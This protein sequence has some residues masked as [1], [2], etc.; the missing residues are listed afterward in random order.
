MDYTELLCAATTTYIPPTLDRTP[1]GCF[2][3]DVDTNDDIDEDEFYLVSETAFSVV[4]NILVYIAGYVVRK[5]RKQIKCTECQNVLI[6]KVTDPQNDNTH[7][8]LKTRNRGGL[9]T[10]SHGVMKIINAAEKHLRTMS[11]MSIKCSSHQLQAKVLSDVGH[12]PL[13]PIV[14][15]FIDTQVGIENHFF[16]LLR[17]VVS[18]FFQL[19]QHHIVRL[20]NMQ[21]RR[22]VIRQK[23][24]K[25]IIFMG[26]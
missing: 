9:I 10:P 19:R 20:H 2:E 22:K 21:Q 11:A 25:S 18:I 24:T 14:H 7:I 6:A 26:Q 8:L 1:A 15:H 13:F 23:L 5:C 4:G 3:Q 16:T 12:L 17:T